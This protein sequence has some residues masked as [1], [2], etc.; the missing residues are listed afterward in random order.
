MSLTCTLQASVP[1]TLVEEPE[2]EANGRRAA[3]AAAKAQEECAT[4]TRN[5]FPVMAQ[6]AVR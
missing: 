3:A 4:H 2:D 1:P 5:A 6:A